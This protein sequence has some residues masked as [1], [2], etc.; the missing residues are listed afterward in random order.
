MDSYFLA[1]PNPSEPVRTGPK[2]FGDWLTVSEAVTYCSIKELQRTPK[3]IRK[4]AHRSHS[5]PE[6]A[7]LV[8]RREDVDNGFRWSIERES[9]DR[10]IAQEHEFEA[11]REEEPVQT[12]SHPAEQVHTAVVGKNGEN[13]HLVSDEP[14]RTALNSSRP[15]RDESQLVS[16][17]RDRI[18]GLNDEV[19]FYREEL[20]DRRLTTAAL[21]DVIEAFRLTAHTNSQRAERESEHKSQQ[22]RMFDDGDNRH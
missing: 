18:K 12:G 8:V 17:L 7:D 10:K 20:R 15:V 1:A 14:V 9:L 4:W 13:E 16:E 3:T 21:A 2:G 5:D 11:R 6:N 22:P 19:D